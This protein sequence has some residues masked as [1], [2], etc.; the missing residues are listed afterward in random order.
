MK[1]KERR[2]GTKSYPCCWLVINKRSSEGWKCVH[3]CV[4]GLLSLEQLELHQFEALQTS[5]EQKKKS[6][7]VGGEQTGADFTASQYLFQTDNFTEKRAKANFQSFLLVCV[8]AVIFLSKGPSTLTE[9]R[10][11]SFSF[12]KKKE[13]LRG[14]K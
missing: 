2:S 11:K 6:E 5:W 14:G 10:Q 1:T 13:K 12:G 4:R 8:L 3:V 9:I 7:E